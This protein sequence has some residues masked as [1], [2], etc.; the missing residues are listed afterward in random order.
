MCEI[1]AS[2]L[3]EDVNRKIN[4]MPDR[5]V[6]WANK[7]GLAIDIKQLDEHFDKH[8]DEATKK[9][10]KKTARRGVRLG[11]T[12]S[13]CDKPNSPCKLRIQP[14]TE[15]NV[16]RVL[17]GGKNPTPHYQG[18]GDVSVSNP[19][20]CQDEQLLNEI[21]ARVFDELNA[22]GFTLKLEHGF[23]A[24]EIK[25]KL[26]GGGDAER[27]LMDLLNEIRRQELASDG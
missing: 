13:S 15:Q 19:T 23:K 4:W 3:L 12:P 1:C 5:L 18:D 9:K 10:R 25:Q 6:K 20:P 24:I 8:I 21:I 22:G 26:S 16:G 11:R 2:P 14:A 27:L 17:T 7:R